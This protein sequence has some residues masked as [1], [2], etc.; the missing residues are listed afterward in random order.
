MNEFLHVAL[1]MRDRDKG[2]ALFQNT[3]YFRDHFYKKI[4]GETADYQVK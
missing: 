3:G 2:S 4:Q 1:I